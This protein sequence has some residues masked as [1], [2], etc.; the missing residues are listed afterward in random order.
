MGPG[1]AQVGNGDGGAGGSKA[2]AAVLVN[3]T[4]VGKAATLTCKRKS[5]AQSLVG[6]VPEEAVDAS[7]DNNNDDDDDDFEHPPL[8][9]KSRRPKPPTVT[10]VTKAASSMGETTATTAKA[11]AA[12]RKRKSRASSP[13]PVVGED[14]MDTLE[15]LGDE[16]LDMSVAVAIKKKIK[17][18][19]AQALTKAATPSRSSRRSNRTTVPNTTTKAGHAITM[20]K[21]SASSAAMKVDSVGHELHNVDDDDLVAPPPKRRAVATGKHEAVSAPAQPTPLSPPPVAKPLA[22]EKSTGTAAGWNMV[23]VGRQRKAKA[24]AMAVQPHFAPMWSLGRKYKSGVSAVPAAGS[25]NLAGKEDGK[26]TG[27]DGKVE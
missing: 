21:E 20:T 23:E 4:M 17:R 22:T 27:V 10:A 26:A 9:T 3:L 15:M 6:A 5:R 7:D 12:T 13:A 14:T 18:E 16:D 8:R 2:E 1:N 19:R 25:S 24:A 11:A